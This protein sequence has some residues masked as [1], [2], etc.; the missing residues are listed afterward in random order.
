MKYPGDIYTFVFAVPGTSPNVT[1][2]PQVTV[3]DPTSS[4]VI[5][6]SQAM[7][8]ISGSSAVYTYNWNTT[9][10]GNGMYVA[11]VS[12]AVSGTPYSGVFLE[13]V[14]LGD[15]RVTGVVALD[16]TVAKDSTVAH[17]ATVFKITDFIAP[18]ADAVIQQILGFVQR[19]PTA[20]ATETTLATV[21]SGV[22]DIR[23][24]SLGTWVLDKVHNTLT[25][26]RVGGG[27]LAT[28]NLVNNANNSNRVAA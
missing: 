15:S 8:L 19:I 9:G 22:Q 1:A 6:A 12:Y 4:S 26:N 21:A 23:D 25:L 11:L 17:D 28:F 5:V 14:Q 13:R 2:T 20:P 18:S 3:V 10:T 16:A 24:Y 27:V 7:T